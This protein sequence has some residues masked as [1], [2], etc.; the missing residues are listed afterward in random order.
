M[1]L[2]LSPPPPPPFSARA[3][4]PFTYGGAGATHPT[5]ASHPQSPPGDNSGLPVISFIRPLPAPAII[6]V[7]FLRI[8]SMRHVL[9]F[10]ASATASS[11][12]VR[13]HPRTSEVSAGLVPASSSSSSSSLPATVETS[14]RVPPWAAA[15]RLALNFVVSVGNFV[16][17]NIKAD[18]FLVGAWG[19]AHDY[20]ARGQSPFALPIS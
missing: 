1:V 20:S 7:N 14:P 5:E 2:S 16:D 18:E 12:G 11:G 8:C 17:A 9:S 6:F 3:L 19:D 4:L 10:S 13:P 15:F